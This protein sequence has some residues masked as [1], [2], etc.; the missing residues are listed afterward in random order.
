MVEYVRSA[1]RIL[2]DGDS[3]ALGYNAQLGGFRPGLQSGLTAAG[4][5][6][7]TCGPLSDAWGN[8]NAV[9]AT[10]LSQKTSGFQTI[11]ANARPH[12]IVINQG[13]NDMG[14]V[15]AGGQGRTAAQTHTALTAALDC[16]QTA[17]PEAFC[18]VNKVIVPDKNDIPAY[19]DARFTIAD[20]NAGLPSLLAARSRC[21]LI[22]IGAPE[23]SDGVHPT[24][25]G[26]ATMA[27][28]VLAALLA[29][30]PGRRG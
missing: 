13:V 16:A 5:S 25:T 7:T 28:Q 29:V 23:T 11:V 24:Q 30:L 19:Y 6:W 26:Y 21:Y 15:A 14:G 18:F 27:S 10:A 8:H 9:I 1:G 20:Y 4:V 12:I 3:V 2:V 22:D 17:A